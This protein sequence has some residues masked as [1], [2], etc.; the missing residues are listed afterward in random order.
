MT[1]LRVWEMEEYSRILLL[2]G[3]ML[4]QTA[5]D[6][7]FDD[8][9]AQLMRTK[10]D[11]GRLA[12]EPELPSEYLLGGLGEVEDDKHSY[13]PKQWYTGWRS[14]VKAPGFFNAGFFLLK[15][16]KKLFKYFLALLDLVD[17][18]DPIYP[19]QNLLNYAFRWNGAMP[20]SEIAYTWNIRWATEADL[21][22]GVASLH[23]KW[24]QEPRSRSSKVKEFFLSKRWQMEGYY[25]ARDTV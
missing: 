10:P 7:V 9:G 2:D 21:K 18:F 24:W 13:P 23:E 1:K 6:S 17:R 22:G 5:L 25:K 4:L 8:P 16:D 20:W 14:D 11:V 19:E 12:D 15:P 3:D